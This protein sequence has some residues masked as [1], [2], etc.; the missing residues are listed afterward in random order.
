MDDAGG[1]TST[2]DLYRIDPAE[3]WTLETGPPGRR[4]LQVVRLL[5]KKETGEQPVRSKLLVQAALGADSFE[6][7]NDED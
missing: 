2:T 7:G 4:M 3:S 5:A 1:A 6:G